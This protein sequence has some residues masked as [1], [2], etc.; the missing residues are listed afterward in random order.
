[1]RRL[2]MIV[3]AASLLFLGTLAPLPTSSAASSSAP[4]TAAVQPLVVK[5]V[6]I[7]GRRV[8]FV[9]GV[10]DD[11]K[12]FV[13]MKL[14]RDGRWRTVASDRT[15]CHYYDGSHDPT[16]AVQKPDKQVFVTWIGTNP[17]EV[18]AEYGGYNVHRRTIEMFGVDPEVGCP[19]AG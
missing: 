10:N 8:R 12:A 3:T 13:Q 16:L 1:M 15:D 17:E 6:Q 5:T 14:R 4:R 18:A 11:E 19:A 2:L 7:G 9:L